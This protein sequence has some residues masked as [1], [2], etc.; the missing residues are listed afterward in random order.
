MKREIKFRGKRTDNDKLVYGYYFYDSI[1]DKHFILT[2]SP[3]G[4]ILE[5]KVKPE[6]VSQ[7]IGRKDKNGKEIYHGDRVKLPV[8][9]VGSCSGNWYRKTNVHH[10][11][12]M[13]EFTVAWDECEA[14]FFLQVDKEMLKEI[15]KPKGRERFEQNVSYPRDF[16]RSG[17]YYEIEK[18]LEVVEDKE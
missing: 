18:N 15:E 12:Y 1:K 16:G 11:P 17:D 7:Y 4:A 13:L 10:K 8:D 3:T 2:Q 14:S 9:R 6:T 5:N